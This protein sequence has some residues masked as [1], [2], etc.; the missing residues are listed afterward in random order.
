MGKRYERIWNENKC[1][2]SSEINNTEDVN[3]IAGEAK[4]QLIVGN[5]IDWESE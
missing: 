3:V 4:I 5:K 1:N 2:K